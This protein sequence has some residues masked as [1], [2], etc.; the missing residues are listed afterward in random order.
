MTLYERIFPK[1]EREPVA[2]LENDINNGNYRCI[3]LVDKHNVVGV[4]LTD[5]YPNAGY[6]LLS[7]LMVSESFQ[8]NQYG[9]QLTH[10]VREYFTSLDSN[11][12]WM[13]IE[14]EEKVVR[15]YLKLGFKKLPIQ[16]LSPHFDD[17]FS[18]PMH[19]LYL[20]KNDSDMP[21]KKELKKL[22]THIYTASYNLPMSDPRLEQQ[23]V[24]IS[25]TTLGTINVK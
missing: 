8:G 7:Y 18:T 13:L 6:I 25:N 21:D 24:M 23:L 14:A 17:E 4:T 22:I 1:W 16:Y 5:V 20:P 10:E 2:S 12:R 3:A 9:K 19:L 11:Y 15:F